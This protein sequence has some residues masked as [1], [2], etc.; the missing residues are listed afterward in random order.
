L[1]AAQK[2]NYIPDRAAQSLALGRSHNLGLVLVQPHYQVFR[3]PFIPNIITGMSQIVQSNGFRLLVEHIHD[4]DNINIITDMLK[5]GEVAGVVVNTFLGIEDSIIS[6]IR[7]GYP[8]V[9]LDAVSDHYYAALIDHLAGVKLAAEH[10]VRLGHTQIGC[11]TFAPINYHIKRRLNAFREGLATAGIALPQTH[12][13]EGNY[14]P[15]SGY[16]AMQ[17]LL[18]AQP[19]LT[20][21]FGMNDMMAI[22][23][24]RAIHEAG[25]RIPEDIAVVGYDDMRFAAFTNPTLTTVQAPEVE[26]GQLAAEM[27]IALIQG[28]PLAEKCVKLST[29]LVVRQSCGA[30]H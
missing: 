10:L 14:D 22:G 17:A 21:I 5:G 15:E 18:Q 9:L 25:L 8:I 28:V 16:E 6:L 2:L 20:A 27:L 3:D 4:L 7:E 19:Q 26:V 30:A 23:A 12:I 1:Q 11:I 13:R 24:M 29:K